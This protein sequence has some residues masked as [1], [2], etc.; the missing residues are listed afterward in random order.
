MTDAL[1]KL[2]AASV[3]AS[4]A[5]L[6][7]VDPD[8]AADLEAQRRREVTRP[9]VVVVGE[10]KRG[11]SSLVN[12]LH[13]GARPVPGRPGRGHLR[14]P[15]VPPRR[16]GRRA[17][18]TSPASTSPCRWPSNSCATGPPSWAGCPTGYARP[19]ASRSP[20]RRRCCST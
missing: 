20:T 15:G 13:R 17:A 8:A 4:L 16:P 19:G 11:K 2:L 12:A 6:R 9:S 1:G 18:R 14:V 10:T 3:D 7:R 5:F